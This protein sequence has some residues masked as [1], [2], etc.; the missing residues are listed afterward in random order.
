MRIQTTFGRVYNF[1]FFRLI[2]FLIKKIIYEK[3]IT[4]FYFRV[5]K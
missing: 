3:I 4:L 5:K 1:I 2:L